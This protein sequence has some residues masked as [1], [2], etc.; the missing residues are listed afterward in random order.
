MVHGHQ[1]GR[2]A[3]GW[4]TWWNDQ[5]GGRT[6]IGTADVLI[7]AHLH[8]LRVQDHGDGRLFL[9]IPALDGGSQWFKARK[10]DASPSR[11]VSFWTQDGA[12]WGLDPV[13][14]RPDTAT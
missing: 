12:V 1:F 7:A 10:G 14:F 4:R 5:G 3:N 9:Q 13:T 11:M 2:G 8:H 6:P